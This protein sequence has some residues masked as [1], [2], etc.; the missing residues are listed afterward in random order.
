MNELAFCSCNQTRLDSGD[1]QYNSGPLLNGRI[2][3]MF[4]ACRVNRDF[5]R[6]RM[7]CVGIM[8][9]KS[10]TGVVHVSWCGLCVDVGCLVI[11]GCSVCGDVGWG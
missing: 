5:D 3:R 7:V 4:L 6:V 10:M 11:C 2:L 8:F 9:R 1:S